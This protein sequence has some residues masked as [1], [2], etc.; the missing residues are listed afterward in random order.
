M[1]LN[2]RNTILKSEDYIGK[3]RIAFCD[4]LN[5]WATMGTD[6]IEDEEVR[7]NTN[8]FITFALSNP[9]IYITKLATLVISEQVIKEAVEITDVNVSTALAHVLATALPYLL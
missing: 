2:E 9:G 3:V 6:I 1:T 4:W 5:Y 7:T 8:T